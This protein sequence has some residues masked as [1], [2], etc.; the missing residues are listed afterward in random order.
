MSVY[1]VKEALSQVLEMARANFV[2]SVD[3]T[4]AIDEKSA[5][6]S[7]KG[8]IDLPFGL[9]KEI[10]VG[11]FAKGEVAQEA[12][13][14]G[15]DLVGDEALIQEMSDG[16]KIECDWFLSTPDMMSSVS[17]LARI[18]GPRNLMPN[19]KHQTLIT[20]SCAPVIKKIKSGRVKY[21]A[22]SAGLIHIK[23]GN[24]KCAVGDLE[25]NVNECLNVVQNLR[26]DNK[27]VF[28]KVAYL[29]TSM[30]RGSVKLKVN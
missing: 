23:V 7:V 30:S 1:N 4:V 15:A 5:K 13:E 24:V 10:K 27:C 17:R 26:F 22:D 6:N 12:L 25:G 16:K 11:V 19:P 3:L 8:F 9:G 28:I 20:S 2:E 14:A 21:K 18:L 29:S